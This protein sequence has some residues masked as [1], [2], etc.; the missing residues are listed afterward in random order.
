MAAEIGGIISNETK[1]QTMIQE[2]GYFIVMTAP[3]GD[4]VTMVKFN[5]GEARPTVGQLDATFGESEALGK[6]LRY[7]YESGST[8]ARILIAVEPVSSPADEGTL[9]RS[10]TAQPAN[11]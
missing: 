9:V 8:G 6:G 7:D 1:T 4:M 3:S 10:L 11:D 5:F 2:D